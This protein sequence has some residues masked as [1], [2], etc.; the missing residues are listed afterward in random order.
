MSAPHPLQ[1]LGL[2]AEFLGLNLGV[3]KSI[4]ELQQDYEVGDILKTIDDGGVDSGE[5]KWQCPILPAFQS[6][7]AAE[8]TFSNKSPCEVPSRL[9]NTPFKDATRKKPWVLLMCCDHWG[10]LDPT[11]DLGAKGL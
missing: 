11:K 4:F 1:V 7:A 2:S 9:Q 10:S 3:E 8:R 5:P 6:I